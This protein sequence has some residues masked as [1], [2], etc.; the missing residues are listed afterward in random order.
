ML[1]WSYRCGQAKSVTF[2]CSRREHSI[3]GFEEWAVRPAT[4][5]V[6]EPTSLVLLGMGL[7]GLAAARRR[8]S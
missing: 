5:T 1:A 8:R 7:V 6:P 4:P 2:R 3:A